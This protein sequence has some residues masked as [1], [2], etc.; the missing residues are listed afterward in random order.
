[1]A[2]FIHSIL[3]TNQ[4]IAADGD[5][6]F[7]L[8]VLPLSAVLL[9]ISPLNESSTITTYRLLEAL[10]GSMTTVRVTFRGT[11]VVDASATDLAVLAM[12]FHKMTIWQSGVMETDDFRRSIVL[13]VIFG[14]KPYMQTECFPASR[15]GELQLQ[16]TYD[17]AAAGFDGLRMG[18]ETIELPGATPD[19]VQKVTTLAQTFAAVGQNDLELP[20]GN[21]LR[22]VLMF[23]TTAYTG[24]APAPTLGELSVMV[25]NKQYGY[26]A[27]DFEVCRGLLGM[28][29]VP[30]PPDGRHIH[31]VNAAGAGREDTL[32]PE[33]GASIDDNYALL[34]FDPTMDDEY[35]L[36]TAGRGRINVR[37]DAEA[38]EA[39][40]ALPIERVA[41]GEFLEA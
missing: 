6:T 18:I 7:D 30:F 36:D 19:F 2:E 32:E 15:K 16:I 9:H 12:L 24:A 31:S 27:S 10:L 14:R 34:S 3:Q 17:I 8:P 5:E 35:A 29:G 25:D 4:A 13:P 33:I 23:G 37:C 20:I 1:M 26:S 39:V 40:R 11:S 28:A 22:G 41:A 38:A 21:V